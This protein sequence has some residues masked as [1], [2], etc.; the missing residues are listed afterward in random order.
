MV[1]SPFGSVYSRSNGPV[2][3]DLIESWW[4]CV[5]Q[6]DCVFGPFGKTKG[7]PH[8]R[9]LTKFYSK[10]ELRRALPIYIYTLVQDL[11]VSDVGL[12]HHYIPSPCEFLPTH[13]SI[14]GPL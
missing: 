12:V 2:N 10:L 3:L 8:K 7:G 9:E 1:N 6:G 4:P 11:H 5:I 13:S 14:V